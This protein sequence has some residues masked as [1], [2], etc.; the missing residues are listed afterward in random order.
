M[1]PLQIEWNKVIILLFYF[2]PVDV[3]LF[4]VIQILLFYDFS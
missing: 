1:L 4:Q 3:Y 2:T